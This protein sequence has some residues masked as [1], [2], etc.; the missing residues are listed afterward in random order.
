M[1]VTLADRFHATRSFDPTAGLEL[2][3]GTMR[4]YDALSEHHYRAAKPA[5]ATRVLVYACASPGVEERFDR[6][7]ALTRE[8]FDESSCDR[9]A[10]PQRA[11][12][13]ETASDAAVRSCEG[14]GRVV[15]VL[16]ESLPVLSC[17]LR[18]EA[19]CGRYSAW[20]DPRERAALL[21]AEVRCI[22]RVVVHPQ[23]RGAGLAVRL[24]RAALARPTTAV[25]EAI[26]AMG[27]VNP[28]FEKAGMTAYRR[29]PHE[30]DARLR[31]ALES[32][33]LGAE[34]LATP[35]ATLARI[36]A[37][38]ARSRAFVLRELSRWHARLHR[39]TRRDA[40]VKEQMADA[41]ARLMCEPAYYVK[42]SE[43]FWAGTS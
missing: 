27:E 10:Q 33:G 13:R 25:T 37:M 9:D 28:F 42:V 41:R 7:G 1:T 3:L 11:E 2:R 35:G 12:T 16:V 5:T 26:A 20:T 24:V 34:S 30:A 22:S 15:A 23:W 6:M 36:E 18:D 17:R 4:D 31:A 14:R 38:P 8:R 39:G 19:L 21:N 32:V 40:G 43:A 29:P